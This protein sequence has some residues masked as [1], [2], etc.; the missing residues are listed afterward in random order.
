M[1]WEKWEALT[2]CLCF[3]SIIFCVVNI[4]DIVVHHKETP[5]MFS[6]VSLKKLYLKGSRLWLF[7][8]QIGTLRSDNGDVH[9]NVV[10]K[11]TLCPF[12]LFCDNPKS[13]ALPYPFSSRCKIWPFLR[14]GKEI[15]KK[16][17]S[18]CKVVILLI[19]PIAFLM[20]PFPLLL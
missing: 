9:E 6:M 17:W 4:S 3:S 20:F 19:K 2:W 14:D 18:T 5:S 12:K 8:L 1:S 15:H 7:F 11:Y 13:L 16:A 10:E